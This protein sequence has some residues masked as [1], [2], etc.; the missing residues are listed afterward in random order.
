MDGEGVALAPVDVAPS[1]VV[2]PLS[3]MGEIALADHPITTASSHESVKIKA[4]NAR[5]KNTDTR[6]KR[7]L[8]RYSPPGTPPPRKGTMDTTSSRTHRNYPATS[9]KTKENIR[10]QQVHGISSS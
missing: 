10:T 3:K 5:Q 4:T 8:I 7:R 1:R 9:H 2:G 6:E